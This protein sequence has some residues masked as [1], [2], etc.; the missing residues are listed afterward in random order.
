M[1]P[2]DAYL[3]KFDGSGRISKRKCKFLRLIT[4][5]N[6]VLAGTPQN[7]GGNPQNIGGNPATSGYLYIQDIQSNNEMLI[8]LITIMI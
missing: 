6:D 8:T 7:S 4:P 5:Y 1:L 3:V 2:H